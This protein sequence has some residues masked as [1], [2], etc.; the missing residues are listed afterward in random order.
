[1]KFLAISLP[2]HLSLW[3]KRPRIRARPA[4]GATPRRVRPGHDAQGCWAR[5][6]QLTN[7]TLAAEFG[8]Q[9]C[10][11][12]MAAMRTTAEG[13][14]SADWNWPCARQ[15]SNP[16]PLGPPASGGL[17]FWNQSLRPGL[18][19]LG[20]TS[21]RHDGPSSPAHRRTGL[22]LAPKQIRSV[23]RNVCA[24]HRPASYLHSLGVSVS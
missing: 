7:A 12:V 17:S 2:R 20:G 9:N 14:V 16:R 24:F 19:C 3:P 18:F 11:L 13:T 21:R 4:V 1:M 10:Y 5:H 23:P 8:T 22:F 6:D 15:T